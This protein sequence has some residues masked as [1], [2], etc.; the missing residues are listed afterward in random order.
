[1]T[2]EKGW[3]IY[4]KFNLIGPNGFETFQTPKYF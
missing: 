3:H 2:E 1:M 4:E